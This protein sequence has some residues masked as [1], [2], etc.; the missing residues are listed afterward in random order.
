MIFFSLLE[1]A[2]TSIC[3]QKTIAHTILCTLS[4]MPRYVF[5]RERALFLRVNGMNCIDSKM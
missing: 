5:V 3:N 4:I 1:Q 2:H